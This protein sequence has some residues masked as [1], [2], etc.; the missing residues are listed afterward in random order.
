[1]L[2]RECLV[3]WKCGGIG[4]GNGKNG[5]KINF[6]C[7]WLGGKVRGKKIMIFYLNA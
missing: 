3:G 4:V 2:I 7:T 6:E 1:M 5:K